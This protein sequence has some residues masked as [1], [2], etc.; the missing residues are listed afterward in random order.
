MKTR[1]RDVN[2]VRILDL[3]GKITIGSGDIELRQRIEDSVASGTNNILLNF[4]G[5]THIDSSGIGELV[6]CYTT[7]ARRGG[8]MKLLNLTQKITDILHVTQLITVFDVYDSEAE[9]LASFNA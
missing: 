4:A 9:A 3:E 7:M 6:G 5:V 1:I 8:K 2:N